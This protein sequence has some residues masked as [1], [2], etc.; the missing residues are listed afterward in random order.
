MTTTVIYPK[1]NSTIERL[2]NGENVEIKEVPTFTNFDEAKPYL[3]ACGKAAREI[4][5][6]HDSFFTK[7]A[8]KEVEEAWYKAL[9]ADCGYMVY[10]AA[11]LAFGWLQKMYVFKTTGR[12][13]L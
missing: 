12:V 1:D 5:N 8:M 6:E 7:M 11:C 9:H 10:N 3:I 2:L 4:A 13:A